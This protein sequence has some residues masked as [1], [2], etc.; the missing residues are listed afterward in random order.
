MLRKESDSLYLFELAG[1]QARYSPRMHSAKSSIP[2]L[3][4]R[5]DRATKPAGYARYLCLKEY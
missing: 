2:D 3:R 1:K 5:D 4:L